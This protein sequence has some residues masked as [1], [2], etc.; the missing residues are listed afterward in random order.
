[1]TSGDFQSLEVPAAALA[2]S[3]EAEVI[4]PGSAPVTIVRTGDA[5]RVDLK[6][7][8]SGFLVPLLGGTWHVQLEIDPSGTTAEFRYP[9]APIDKVLTPANGQ[10]TESISMKDVLAPG[11]YELVASLTYSD[12]TG[13]A[14]PMGGFV[15]L[16]R[17][18]VQP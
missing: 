18:Q 1:M 17:I 3:F 10:Y 5:W 8:L 7:Q 9:A 16:N 11:G 2:G 13:T 6:W 14:K 15:K 12:A 4:D